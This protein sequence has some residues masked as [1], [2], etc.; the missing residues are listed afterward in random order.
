MSYYA[1]PMSFTYHSTER[2]S[3]LGLQVALP[4]APE[5]ILLDSRYTPCTVC[6]PTAP[7]VPAGIEGPKGDTGPRGER[8]EAG[9]PSK[10]PCAVWNYITDARWNRPLWFDRY[11][12]LGDLA[13]SDGLWY[14][15]IPAGLGGQYVFSNG[16]WVE[17]TTIN[18]VIAIFYGKSLE[19]L[20]QIII[21]KAITDGKVKKVGE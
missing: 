15:D 10:Q 8:G 11:T 7:S 6:N 17:A 21:D 18:K 16:A 9:P 20:E 12:G 4:I 19:E 13:L 14:A 3:S 1:R 5:Q 2:C